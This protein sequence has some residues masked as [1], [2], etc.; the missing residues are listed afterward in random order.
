MF[1]WVSGMSVFFLRT[2][3]E[4]QQMN[5]ALVTS[6]RTRFDSLLVST[7]SHVTATVFRF[8]DGFFCRYLYYHFVGN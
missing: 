3:P 7:S 8:T 2:H 5:M 1:F 4:C 6:F